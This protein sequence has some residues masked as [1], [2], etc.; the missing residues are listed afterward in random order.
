MDYTV[1]SP[2]W[3]KPKKGE[4]MKAE[5]TIEKKKV[6]E[7]QWGN[8]LCYMIG[9]RWYSVFE[10]NLKD[11]HTKDLLHGLKEGDEVEF[12]ITESPNKK[13]PGEVFYNIVGAT[14]VERLNKDLDVPAK[15]Q[16][17]GRGESDTRVRS[18]ALSYAKDLIVAG[19]IG[20]GSG[21]GFDEGQDKAIDLAKRFEKYIQTGE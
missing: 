14:R 8:R 9:K 7:T 6:E 5:G 1:G 15:V 3:A 18:M 21:H 17:S 11:T 19:G 16:P 20:E 10:T 13:K 12:E 2:K 4:K